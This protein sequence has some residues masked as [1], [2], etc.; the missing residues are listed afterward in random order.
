M[1]AIAATVS[2]R[3]AGEPDG[4]GRAPRA[5]FATGSWLYAAAVRRYVLLLVC[6]DAPGIVADVAGW[7][8][9]EGG[10][11]IDAGQ[12]RD[13]EH[14]LFLQRVEAEHPSDVEPLRRS[15][16]DVAERWG[17][18][19]ELHEPRP[20]ARLAVLVSREAHCLYDL[21]GRCATGDLPAEV[22]L[23]LSNHDDH[24]VAA[25]R[26]GV[27]FTHAPVVDGDRAAQEAVVAGALRSADPDL[28]VL[29]RY[30]RVLSPGFCTEF[31][32]RTINIHH[33]FLP[34]FVGA[35]AYRQAWERGVK[36]IGATAHYITADLDQ[37]PIIAQD[38]EH[39]SHADIPADMARR[40][41]ELEARVLAAAV[42]AHLE[43]RVIAYAN[44]TVLFE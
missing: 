17:M 3:P 36:L 5:A 10:N 40:G 18:R 30:M 33:S 35:D 20:T 44:R 22:A 8:A 9:S 34:A 25:E 41:R 7:V 23:V 27:P 4:A 42:R 28:I 26:F 31:G 21:L 29:A 24:R 11:I 19:W 14:G 1:I 12:Y 15:F 32:G 16:A 37:G 38:V 2:G 6:P 43:H 39:V 13:A